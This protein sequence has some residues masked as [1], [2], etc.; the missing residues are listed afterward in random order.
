VNSF[1]MLNESV[2]PMHAICVTAVGRFVASHAS[3]PIV[4]MMNL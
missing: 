4:E 3:D 1:V 2:D